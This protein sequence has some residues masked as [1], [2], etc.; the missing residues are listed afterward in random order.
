MVTRTTR[1]SEPVSFPKDKTEWYHFLEDNVEYAI[2]VREWINSLPNTA[3][4]FKKKHLPEGHTRPDYLSGIL[5][6]SGAWKA[7]TT[8][9]NVVGTWVNPNATDAHHYSDAVTRCECGIPVVRE[10]FSEKE[11]QPNHH[12]S[13]KESCNKIH[14]MECRVQLLKNRKEIIKDQY[15]HNQSLEQSKERLG[16]TGAS[17]MS[18]D[19]VADIGLDIQH[20]SKQARK[21]FARTCMVL[22]REHNPEI[23]GRIFGVTGDSIARMIRKETKSDVGKLYAVRRNL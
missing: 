23:I 5:K 14:R 18:G 13:H 2:E 8:L 3:T 12:Q 19:E 16:Y 20:L 22:A 6:L 7:P 11:P 1:L 4:T 10:Q 9:F 17:R 15:A 21:R